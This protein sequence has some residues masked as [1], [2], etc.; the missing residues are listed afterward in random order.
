[1]G[2]TKVAFVE[3]KVDAA[4][5]QGILQKHLLPVVG[6]FRVPWHFQQD[7]ATCHSARS[8]MAWFAA[9]GL[10]PPIDWP[11]HSPDVSPIENLWSLMVQDVNKENPATVDDLRKAIRGSWRARTSDPILMENLLGGWR[12]R[13]LQLVDAKG[14]RLSY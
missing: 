13:V 8:T 11:P 9:N 10:P 7:G 2:S 4:A 3:G 14:G 6:A 1:L 12:K 5:Y